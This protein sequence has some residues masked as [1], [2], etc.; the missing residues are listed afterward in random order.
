MMPV[1]S[2]RF[3]YTI[4]VMMMLL[5]VINYVDRGAIAY[6]AS[7]IIGEYHLDKAQWGAVLGYFGYGYMVG[8]V[9]GGTFA[10]TVGARRVWWIAGTAWS[11]FE[12]AT[13]YA[14]NIGIALFGGGSALVGFAMIR[15]LFGLSEG[16]AYAL[17]NKTVGVWAT[18]RERGFAASVGLLSTPLGAL[19]TAPIAVGLLTLT[20]DWR[21]MFFVLGGTGL[22]AL[23]VLMVLFTNTPEENPRV[24]PA[25][26]AEIREAQA[27]VL[28]P[29][30]HPDEPV[31]PLWSFFTNP[32]L[33]L[34]TI[35]YFA[36]IY[37][38]FLLLTWTPKYLQDQFHFS[39]TSLWYIGM[40]PWTGSCFTV[41]IGGRLSDW[42]YQRTGKL[43]YARSCLA[44]TCLLLTTV[45]FY[46]VSQAEN[47]VVAIALMTVANAM[48]TLPNSV[49]WTVV[50]DSAPRS[51]V[52]TF[53]GMMLFFA[54][55]ASVLAPTV[56]G[57]LTMAYGY[58][59]MFIAAGITT[60]VG[61]TAMLFVRPGRKA[62]ALAPRPAYAA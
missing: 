22:V 60:A 27:T 32:A 56:T 24:S 9:L 29:E 4:F 16:P 18:P 28:M 37:V 6:A 23:V 42:L 53:S 11:L 41:L 51:R 1:I 19:L 20:G 14:G 25:E 43:Y 17:L 49:Y 59:A 45:C 31:P 52:G 62:A 13:A 34:N 40:I 61:M 36:F 12:I 57:S 47:I 58:Q 48:N 35:G 44:A 46:F 3:R 15:I 21:I 50:I 55:I 10:D 26:L 2:S 5:T 8:A 54:L 33:V 7:A 38:T 39:L 30:D